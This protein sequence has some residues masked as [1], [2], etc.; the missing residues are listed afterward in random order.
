M[1]EETALVPLQKFIEEKAR[2]VFITVTT[3]DPGKV[4]LAVRTIPELLFWGNKDIAR[5]HQGTKETTVEWF[6]RAKPKDR[7]QMEDILS[8]YQRYC[9]EHNDKTSWKFAEIPFSLADFLERAKPQGMRIGE[10]GFDQPRGRGIPWR[11]VFLPKGF[12]NDRLIARVS[13][14]NWNSQTEV[15]VFADSVDSPDYQLMKDLAG[16]YEVYVLGLRGVKPYL[17]L[18]L[19]YTIPE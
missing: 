6:P 19:M 11:Y 4:Y 17:T 10:P 13:Y 15:E 1:K 7:R 3:T 9:K 18:K 16:R 2:G 14:V 12:L 5:I 8:S